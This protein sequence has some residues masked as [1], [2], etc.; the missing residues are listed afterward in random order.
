MDKLGHATTGYLTGR[1][2]YELFKSSG[3][4]EKQSVWFGGSLG[5]LYLLNIEILDGFS[6]EWGA[7]TGDL[8]ANT[9]GASLFI[10]QQLAWKEQRI[11]LK[12]SFHS[13]KYPNYRPNLLGSNLLEQSVKDYNGQ[14][15][16]LSFNPK[17]F[18]RNTSALPNWLNFAIGYSGEGMVSGEEDEKLYPNIPDFKRYRQFFFSP[19]IDFTKIKTKSRFL[20][21]TFFVLNI[22][23]LPFPALEYSKNRFILHPMYF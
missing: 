13:T 6:E 8:V 7:S 4:K 23:K 22:F 12:Y 21:K 10:G 16:W 1:T 17:S 18:S 20:R 14:T 11:N 9:L 5:F 15:Y 2:G 3:L 19:D